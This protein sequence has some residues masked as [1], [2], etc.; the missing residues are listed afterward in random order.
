MTD[1]LPHYVYV[2]LALRRGSKRGVAKAQ[3]QPHRWHAAHA[4]THNIAPSHSRLMQNAEQRE[5]ENRRKG[6]RREEKRDMEDE[7][8]RQ[9]GTRFAAWVHM[10]MLCRLDGLLPCEAPVKRY[11]CLLYCCHNI[12]TTHCLLMNRQINWQTDRLA[13]RQTNMQT[14]AREIER[15]RDRKKCALNTVMEIANEFFNICWLTHALN[16]RMAW[17]LT[18]I[19]VCLWQLNGICPSRWMPGG[20]Q[21][22][23]STSIA[24]GSRR[25]VSC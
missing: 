6:G 8:Q 12:F 16:L 10:Q 18:Y 17:C 7:R 13:D 11:C 19:F 2:T 3:L 20:S 9:Q 5:A 24:S 22:V 14:N 23:P 1:V 25:D 4:T 15:G 21:R